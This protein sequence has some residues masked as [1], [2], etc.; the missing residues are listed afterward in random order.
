MKNTPQNKQKPAA[1]VTVKPHESLGQADYGWLQARYHFSFGDYRD[2]SRMG[3]GKLRVIND[4]IVGPASGFDTHPHRDMEIITYVRSGAITHRDSTGNEG[5]TESGDVQVMS[6]GTGIHHSERNAETLPTALYQI[7][8]VPRER[9]VAPRWEARKFPKTPVTDSL[10]LLV[11]GRAADQNS[12]ALMIHAD[13]AIYGGRLNQGASITQELQDLG[14][15]L[16]SEGK[17][18]LNGTPMKKGDGAE[19]TNADEIEITALEDAEIVLIDVS[20]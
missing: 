8:I 1:T 10:N 6:A 9:G 15:L 17:I 3:F 5:R 2:P 20:P 16:V 4:D 14:Y 18:T 11:S 19:I 7:W 12:D 13:A